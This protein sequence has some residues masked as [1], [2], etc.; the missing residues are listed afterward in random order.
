MPMT[1]TEGFKVLRG[2]QWVLA[3]VLACLT[4]TAAARANATPRNFDIPAQRAP[5]AVKALAQ[6]SGLQIAAL[7]E[8][9]GNVRTNEVHGTYEPMEALQRLIAGT[10]LE[11]G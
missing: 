4:V 10:G 5:E 1:C 11:V 6:Q 3:G 8:D 9:L 7:S 2:S